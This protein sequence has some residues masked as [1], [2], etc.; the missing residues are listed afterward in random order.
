[1]ERCKDTSH[2]LPLPTSGAHHIIQVMYQC[3]GCES[4]DKL[5]ATQKAVRRRQT[6]HQ[7]FDPSQDREQTTSWRRQPRQ[8]LPWRRRRR[9]RR[10]RRPGIFLAQLKYFVKDGLRGTGK[11]YRIVIFLGQGGSD[12]PRAPRPAPQTAAT[13]AGPPLH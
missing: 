6:A 11:G 3:C 13:A 7:Y 8:P 10:G 12:L 9:P 4:C 1:M 5:F 2:L